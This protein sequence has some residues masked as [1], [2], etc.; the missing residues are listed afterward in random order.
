MLL[1][2]TIVFFLEKWTGWEYLMEISEK[3]WLITLGKF[4]G[5]FRKDVTHNLIFKL[6]QGYE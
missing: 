3:M 6:S 2:L 5:N 1:L 4:N